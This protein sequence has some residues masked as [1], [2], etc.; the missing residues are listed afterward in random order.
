MKTGAAL[1]VLLL[2]IPATLVWAHCQVPCGI[3]HDDLRL[4][5]IDEHIETIEKSM[6]QITS[7]SKAESPNAN[8]IVRWVNN[9]DAHADELINIVTWYF[10]NQ[11]VKPVAAGGAGY[12]AYITQVTLLH[13]MMVNAMKAKQS[14]DIQYV[15][16]LKELLMDF[17]KAYRGE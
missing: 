10:L 7:L 14:T 1:S 4:E 15:E 12:D 11:R 2:L 17:T 8:Q 3:Y 16:R 6:Q 13:E 9:K 5:L